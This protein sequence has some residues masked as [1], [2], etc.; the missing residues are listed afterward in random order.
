M[1]QSAA[2][3]GSK[4]EAP[5]VP[6]GVAMTS[7]PNAGVSIPCEQPDSRTLSAIVRV[8]TDNGSHA[9]GVVF[10]DNR[11]LT[12]AHAIQGAARFY[13]HTGD[14]FH[15]AELIMV[16]HTDDLAVLVVNTL[17]IEPIRISGFGPAEAEPVWAVGYPRA[18]AMSTSFGLFQR[19]R[20]GVLHSS[21]PI[22][23]GQSGGG[24]LSCHQGRWSLAGMLRGYGAYW[25]GDHYV[26]LKNHSVSV[27]QPLSTSFC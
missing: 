7:S 22:D 27:P 9:S 24:L 15:S 5:S 16:D 3:A 17:G 19:S 1:C 4:S 12:A 2:F 10:D 14:A 26:K 18:Q 25:Q 23:P 8:A 13:V 21:A 20:E 6:A 11:V